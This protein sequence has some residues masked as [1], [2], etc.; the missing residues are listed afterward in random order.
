MA[1]DKTVTSDTQT[2]YYQVGRTYTTTPWY[3]PKFDRIKN[4]FI[5]IKENSNLFDRYTFYVIGNSIYDIKNTWD[6]DVVITGD[7]VNYVEL[8]NDLSTIQDIFL[9]KFYQLVDVQWNNGL[10]LEH[11]HEDIHNPSFSI[12]LDFIKH[13][14]VYKKI[15][16]EESYVNKS[17]LDI[18]EKIGNG[19]L[20]KGNYKK[21]PI[22]DK[23]K[24]R[25]SE[26]NKL[27][28]MYP[29]DEYIKH[30]E[31]TFKDEISRYLYNNKR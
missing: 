8:E 1:F 16:E 23:I 2:F 20:I 11:L 21:I 15:G 10:L 12:D 27:I 24:Q 28:N 30:S 9:N 17:D 4:A 22:S 3:R 5:Y 19:L 7:F 26:Y 29:V 18:F 14:Y 31:E 25:I 13:S 6:V